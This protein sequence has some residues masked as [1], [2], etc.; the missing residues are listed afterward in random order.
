[1]LAFYQDKDEGY[2]GRKADKVSFVIYIG[3]FGRYMK[4]QHDGEFIK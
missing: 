3:R 4:R 2:F 1:M